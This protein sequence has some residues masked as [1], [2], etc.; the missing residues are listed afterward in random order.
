MSRR[1]LSI[2]ITIGLI[3]LIKAIIVGLRILPGGS[4]E[5]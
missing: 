2:L 5:T 1:F 4:A 3:S